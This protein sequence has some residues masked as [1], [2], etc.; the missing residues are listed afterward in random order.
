MPPYEK[1]RAWQEAHR[2]VL[3]VY[4]ATESWPARELYGLTSQAR[5]AA[6]SIAANISEGVAKRGRREFRRVLDIALGSTS[7]LS[8]VLRVARDLAL[9]SESNWERLESQRDLAGKLLWRLYESVRG[10]GETQGGR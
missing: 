5:R 2:L 7:E 8:Y 1:L 6:F 9:F 3:S 10:R 4:R